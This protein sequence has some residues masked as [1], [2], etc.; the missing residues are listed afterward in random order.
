MTRTNSIGHSTS[1]A[2]PPVIDL[3]DNASTGSFSVGDSP[4]LV[5]QNNNAHS[6]DLS[7][8]ELLPPPTA[9]KNSKLLKML[10]DDPDNPSQATLDAS[11]K[12]QQRLKE[13]EVGGT[14]QPPSRTHHQVAKKTTHPAWKAA[15]GS[16]GVTGSGA[17]VGAVLGTFVF[18]GVGTAVGAAVGG[19]IGAGV[20]AIE[21]L[22]YAADAKTDWLDSRGNR[23]IDRFQRNAR[24]TPLRML[25]PSSLA[26]GL[27]R[28]VPLS[29]RSRL[30]PVAIAA[31]G[32]VRTGRSVLEA[33]GLQQAKP[34]QVPLHDPGRRGTPADAR[35]YLRYATAMSMAYSDSPNNFHASSYANPGQLLQT[36]NDDIHGDD[37]SNPKPD[38]KDKKYLIAGKF[39]NKSYQEDIENYKTSREI[40]NLRDA[41]VDKNSTPDTVRPDVP[42][43]NYNTLG[44]G[45]RNSV[46]R[47]IFQRLPDSLQQS[48]QKGRGV[49]RDT[50]TGNNIMMMFD[51]VN[52]E[53]VIAHSG[54]GQYS[55]SLSKGEIGRSQ[56]HG[57]IANY[58]GRVPPSVEQSI[59]VGKAV[60]DAVSQYCLDNNIDPPITVTSVGHSRGGLM[61]QAEAL[62]NGGKAVV[63]NAEPMGMGVRQRV[64]MLYSQ[65]KPVDTEIVQI[66]NKN[67]FLTDQHLVNRGARLLETVT[68]IGMPANAGHFIRFDG[69]SEIAGH[70]GF[71][72]HLAHDAV[73]EPDE[74][75]PHAGY[76]WQPEYDDERSQSDP[77]QQINPLYG[78]AYDDNALGWDPDLQLDNNITDEPLPYRSDDYSQSQVGNRPQT[79]PPPLSDNNS[80]KL[81][82]GSGN[83]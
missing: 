80:V 52:N 19:A 23:F 31:T 18:P 51:T 17:A 32:T 5:R 7:P 42:R 28:L 70:P 3:D 26:K 74:V 34:V 76:G 57:N 16:L 60:R 6:E 44:T 39:D 71:L 27:L 73:H 72:A 77:L 50:R 40:D 63:A 11:R 56:W 25:R 1:I 36:L 64:G 29:S 83:D 46:E 41:L 69:D 81:Q 35:A 30:N 48:L 38:Q 75:R 10:G 49:F 22:F 13:M 9:N 58:A 33:T 54:S 12:Q 14:Q 82:Y 68:G 21:S 47:Q 59:A 15:V 43:W 8:F 20:S 78:S 2:N 53:V 62:A 55:L 61:A 24:W 4:R 45:A 66:S 79:P 37:N 67:D 65:D